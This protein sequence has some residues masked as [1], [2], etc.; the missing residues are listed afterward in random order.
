MKHVSN[1]ILAVSAEPIVLIIL[2][3]HAGA[4][5]ELIYSYGRDLLGDDSCI[6]VIFVTHA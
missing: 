2:A 1:L 4:T 3:A 6:V 5:L